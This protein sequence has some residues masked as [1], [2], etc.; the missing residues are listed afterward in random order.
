MMRKN[1]P[2][3]YKKCLAS[4]I[5]SLQD[6]ADKYEYAGAQPPQV[7]SDYLNKYLSLETNNPTLELADVASDE[8]LAPTIDFEEEMRI[9]RREGDEER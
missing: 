6:E 3:Q 1:D 4:F 8:A 5:S 9:D 7:I 2:E